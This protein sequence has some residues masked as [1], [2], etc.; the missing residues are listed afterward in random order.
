M[1]VAAVLALER[2]EQAHETGVRRD[3]LAVAA[4]EERAPLSR[5]RGRILEVI[6][7][8]QPGVAGVEPVDVVH[9]HTVFC[10]NGETPA[11]TG[12]SR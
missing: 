4:L 7:E 3:E 10:S 8:E 2:L 9:A 1:A 11:S 12:G 6:L 5:D